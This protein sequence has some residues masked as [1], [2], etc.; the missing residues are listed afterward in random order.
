LARAVAAP[1]GERE[2]VL[3]GVQEEAQVD[4]A[5]VHDAHVALQREAVVAADRLDDRVLVARQR[6]DRADRLEGR[7]QRGPVG[8]QA[9]RVLAALAGDELAFADAERR[10]DVARAAAGLA[11]LVLLERAAQLEGLVHG[12]GGGGRRGGHG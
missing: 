11:L 10:G 7:E 9:Q 4:R 12:G 8:T 5:A 1:F 2:G 6:H 3:P